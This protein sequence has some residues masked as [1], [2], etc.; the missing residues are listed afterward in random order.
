M[1]FNFSIYILKDIVITIT[2]N[3]DTVNALNALTINCSDGNV[4]YPFH[5]LLYSA[6]VDTQENDNDNANDN[7]NAM[8]NHPLY[9]VTRVIRAF[10][11][12]LPIL[13]SE[14]SSIEQYFQFLNCIC[15]MNLDKVDI[16]WI[17]DLLHFKDWIY[18]SK[19]I[20]TS[21]FTKDDRAKGMTK[22]FIQFPYPAHQQLE[23]HCY[24]LMFKE[25]YNFF[26]SSVTKSGQINNEKFE[27]SFHKSDYVRRDMI[28]K[29]ID[30]FIMNWR[31]KIYFKAFPSIQWKI[32]DFQ[33][34]Y[35]PTSTKLVNLGNGK[36][37]KSTV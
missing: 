18:N 27:W 24:S 34:I 22:I 13:G 37:F 21:S 10:T 20:G 14:F 17:L 35:Y 4:I 16:K 7:V 6:L 5:P 36:R 30:E 1:I 25:L 23:E 31:A 2:I 28:E 19:L 3:M 15:D 9:I 8:L 12:N 26:P 29:A 33:T 11:H 32:N